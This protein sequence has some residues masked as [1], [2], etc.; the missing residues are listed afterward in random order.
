MAEPLVDKNGLTEE[1]FL[2]QYSPKNY[3][4]PSLTA[5]NCVFSIDPETGGLKLLLVRRGGHP[6]LGCWALPGGFVNQGE[7]A[8]EASARELAEETR[9]EGLALERV[10][11]YSTPNRDPRGWTVSAAF[12]ALDRTGAA[13]AAAKAGDDAAATAWFDVVAKGAREDSDRVLLAYSNGTTT[14]AS[15]FNIVRGAVTGMPEAHNVAGT[16]FAFDHAQIVADAY[17]LVASALA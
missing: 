6:Y 17:L 11:L 10:G 16:G 8:D 3:P 9:V 5:D 4:R 14:L 1:E 12:V 7:T 15:E 2:A 13:L